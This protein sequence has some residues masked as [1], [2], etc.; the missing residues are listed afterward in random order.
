MG[1]ALAQFDHTSDD[2]ALLRPLSPLAVAIFSDR[3]YLRTEMAEDAAAAGLRVT[4][5]A[6]LCALIAEPE[7]PLGD[8]V[9][10]DCPVI[11]GTE[12]AAL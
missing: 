3:A 2:V 12:L 10:V 5:T 9:L 11:E 8:L 7:Q 6:D 4:R 1:Q